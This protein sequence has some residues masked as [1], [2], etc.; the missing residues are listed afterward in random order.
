MTIIVQNV[1]KSDK[2]CSIIARRCTTDAITQGKC[3]IEELEHSFCSPNQFC[4]LQTISSQHFGI[5]QR[6]IVNLDNFINISLR[7]QNVVLSM[8]F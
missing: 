8:F 1:E 4:L 5:L 2:L 3:G 7:W 6:M